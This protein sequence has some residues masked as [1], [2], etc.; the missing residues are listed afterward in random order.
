MCLE[1]SYTIFIFI[2]FLQVSKYSKINEDFFQKDTKARLKGFPLAIKDN[3]TMKTNKMK[4]V[5]DYNILN[6]IRIHDSTQL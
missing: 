2:L 6:K 3:C 4:E 5:V 1:Y